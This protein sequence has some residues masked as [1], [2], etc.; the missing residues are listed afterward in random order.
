LFALGQALPDL[1]IASVPA[2]ASCDQVADA[3]QARESLRFRAVGDAETRH[4]REAAGQEGS[5]GVVAA[6]QAVADAGR[7]ADDV[8]QRPGQLDP[9]HIQVRI[10]AEPIRREVLLN[11]AGQVEIAAGDDY[12]GRQIPGDFLGVA[13]TAQY[14]HMADAEELAENL[15]R[16]EE[17]LVFQA[18][19]EAEDWTVSRDGSG[20]CL[21]GRPQVDSR[22][23]GDE[24]VG[25]GDGF[26]DVGSQLDCSWNCHTGQQANVFAPLLKQASVF[27]PGAPQADAMGGV[28]GEHQ[29][30]GRAPGTGA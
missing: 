12:A 26:A 9:D 28:F 16:P 27:R 10:N 29:A 17:A 4:F 19:G 5:L 18:L 24:E 2:H 25:S 23:G 21:K 30:D 15:G 6:I 22:N 20:D 1:T 8:L 11:P 7:D 3:G 13:G 14:G